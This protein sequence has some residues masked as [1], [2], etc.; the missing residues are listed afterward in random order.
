MCCNNYWRLFELCSSDW[1]SLSSTALRLEDYGI[2][3]ARFSDLDLC[4]RSTSSWITGVANP[5]WESLLL[6]PNAPFL[7][8]LPIDLVPSFLYPDCYLRL[9]KLLFDPS[10]SSS[11]S[12]ILL[13]PKEFLDDL[14]KGYRRANGYCFCSSSKGCSLSYTELAE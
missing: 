1:W 6:I 10:Y 13:K 9:L 14:W 2:K 4:M 3:E 7:T 11:F 5:F 8:L 12:E